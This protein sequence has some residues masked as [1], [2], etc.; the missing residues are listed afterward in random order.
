MAKKETAKKKDSAEKASGVSI[1]SLKALATELNEVCKPKPPLSVED[2][3]TLEKEV[4]E[5]VEML[6]ENDKIS[7]ASA[8]TIKALGMEKFLKDVIIK[9]EK[10]MKDKAK[11][12][13]G[14]K[15]VEEKKAKAPKKEKVAKGPGVIATI[16]ELIKAKP[17]TKEQIVAALAK[18]FPDR[19]AESM[20]KTVN[21][22]LGGRLAAE[23]NLKIKNED[24]KY[25]AK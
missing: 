24:G 14:K 9:E 7:A 19:D 8:E 23:K 2:E 15:A 10:A 4:K 22:Q 13:K 5:V 11:A 1:E 6:Q 18:K 25:S 21:V 16:A 3:A 17:M 20:A 12:E